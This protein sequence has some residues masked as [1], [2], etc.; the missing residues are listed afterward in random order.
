MSETKILFNKQAHKEIL[1]GFNLGVDIAKTTLG[2]KGRNVIIDGDDGNFLVSNDGWDAIRSIKLDNKFQNLG[3]KIGKK[4]ARKINNIIGDGRTTGLV[5]AQAIANRGFKLVHRRF[6]KKDSLLLKEE[7]DK[8]TK[9]VIEI[10]QQKSQPLGTREQIIQVAQSACEN[11]EWAEIIA[12][13]FL[14]VGKDG[15]EIEESSLLEVK[16]EK[17]EGMQIEF[18]SILAQI[19]GEKLTYENTPILVVDRIRTLDE[20]IPLFEKMPKRELVI[21]CNDINENVENVLISNKLRN[22]RNTTIVKIPLIKKE[23]L[24]DIAL[25]SGG[26]LITKENGLKLEL[27][28]LGNAQKIIIGQDKAIIIG[29]SSKKEEID[30]KV[31]QLEQ[32]EDLEKAKKR[33]TN[34]TKGVVVVKIGAPNE[35]EL[36]YRKKK[37][38]DAIRTTRLALEEGILPGGG[39][40]LEEIVLKNKSDGSKLLQK[41]IKAPRQ[42][43]IKNAKSKTIEGN[44]IDATKVVITSL[45]IAVSEISTF[46]TTGV[47]L[48]E[49]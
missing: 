15:V 21:F 5:L 49:S 36:N 39:V 18:G 46:L 7:L 31:R 26:K 24:E 28:N 27:Q 23:I 1:K 48:T 16:S 40:A 14:E 38:G 41:A 34:L 13:A 10:L 29:G 37:I 20:I 2:S 42:Q 6:W 8:A 11:K 25:Y 22:T 32:S 17:Q 19:I 45:Q 43:I 9:E 47:S 35:T 33:I 30:L 12:D 44:P 4:I 3:V